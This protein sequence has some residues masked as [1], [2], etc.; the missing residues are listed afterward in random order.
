MQHYLEEH[1]YRLAHPPVIT[2]ALA[3]M[4]VSKRID[5]ALAN[6]RVMGAILDNK[7]P[8][9]DVKTFLLKEKPLYI[10]FGN[11]FIQQYPLFLPVFN[12]AIESCLPK[13]LLPD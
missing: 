13:E 5:A 8:E 9:V 2:E 4:L 7:Y 3:T 6:D 11:H 1:H 10:Y 12:A